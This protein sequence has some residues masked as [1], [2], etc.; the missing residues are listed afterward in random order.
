MD[1]T[2][3]DAGIVLINEETMME[4]ARMESIDGF[5]ANIQKMEELFPTCIKEGKNESG[6]II[7][8]ID[9]EALA[10][11]LGDRVLGEEKY[12]FTWVGKKEAV[13]EANTPIRKTLRPVVADSSEWHTTQNLY[14]EG[15]NLDVL[16]LLQ[17]SYLNAVKVIYIDPPYNTGN[18]FIY[19]DKFN[20]EADEYEKELGAVDEDGNRMFKNLD[21]GGRFHSLWC[22]NIY[23]RLLLARN[24]LTSAGVIFISIDDNEQEN[25]KKICD[26]IFGE[27]NFINCFI[28]NCSTAGGIR[29]KFASKTH[30][31]IYCYAKDKTQV[32]IF[33]A[34]LSG[35]AI[36]MYQQKDENGQL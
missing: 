8:G 34:P 21:T 29:P 13:I 12:E 4:K 14:I 17:V 6:Q 9:M 16:K 19:L 30:E 28:W 35:D 22:S 5:R 7:R 32:P 36:K 18:D 3:K 26:E 2:Q 23:E 25:M 15:E 1:A 31:Y 20:T 11:L 10:L 24:L 27:R 33:Y